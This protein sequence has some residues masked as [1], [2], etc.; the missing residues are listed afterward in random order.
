[1]SMFRILI[2]AFLS[3]LAIGFSEVTYAADQPASGS[4]DMLRNT[5]EPKKL[6]FVD[7]D[8]DGL[9]DLV[10]D[11]NGDGIPDGRMHEGSGQGNGNDRGSRYRQG[12]G[13][14]VVHEAVKMAPGVNSGSGFRHNSGQR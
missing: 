3:V 6:R 7:E 1:M 10:I 5:S 12:V 13:S 4:D 11:R 2:F 14:G 8:G 9:N